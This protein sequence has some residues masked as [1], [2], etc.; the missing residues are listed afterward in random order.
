MVGMV[1]AA[2]I[3]GMFRLQTGNIREWARAAAG[4][5][6]MGIGATFVPGG[7]DTMLF[8]GIPLL[9]PN[10]LAAYAAFVVTLYLAL[11]VGRT[12]DGQQISADV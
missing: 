9:L 2:V 10:L 7:N 4:G 6:L 1:V 8:T 11:Y 5:L 3:G 12:K